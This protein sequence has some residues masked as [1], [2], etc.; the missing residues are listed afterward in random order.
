MCNLHAYLSPW[1]KRPNGAISRQRAT[2][3]R[4]RWAG[5][6]K[7]AKEA[8]AQL[9]KV[10]PGFTVQGW[11]SIHWSDDSTFNAI[12]ARHRRPAQGGPAGGRQEA[13]LNRD[14]K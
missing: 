8:A 9:L 14:S 2:H 13:E 1:S 3:P 5:H 11:A 7:E 10:Y 12:P 6:D 4:L